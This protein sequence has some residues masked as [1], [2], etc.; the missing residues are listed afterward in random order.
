MK[1]GFLI[2]FLTVCFLILSANKC[3]AQK[4]I[5]DST[6][7]MSIVTIQIGFHTPG[8]DLVDRFGNSSSIGLSYGYKN[9]R[10]W[11]FSA[12]G[13]FIFGNELKED[14]A[15]HIRNEDG[16]VLDNNGGLVSL[17]VL[18]R[19]FNFS[20]GLSKTFPIIGPNPNSGLV[21]RGGVG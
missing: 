11:T 2:F 3:Q 8:G 14:V 1:N 13:G 20:V 16:F 17:V 4:S 6:I 21:I 10:N 19:G 15:I 5:K 18:E 9:A 12:E 7:S